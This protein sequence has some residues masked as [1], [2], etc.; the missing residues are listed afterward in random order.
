VGCPERDEVIAAQLDSVGSPLRIVER[1]DPEPGE[2]EVRVRVQACGVCGSDLFLQRGGFVGSPL[3]IIPGHEAAGVVE[4]LGPGVSGLSVG[5]QVAIYYIDAPAGTRYALAGRPNVGPGVRR[6]GVDVDGA[7]AEL[8]VRPAATLITP[9]RPLDPPVLAVL[10]DAVATPYHALVRIARLQPGECLLV[11]GVGGVGSNAVQLGRHF[12]ARVVAVS[13]SATKLALAKR[14]G[15]DEV[16]E[17]GPDLEGRIRKVTG[18]AGP[19][20]V[21]QCA[22]SAHLDAVAINVAGWLGRVVFV[23]T[24]TEAFE[25]KATS[26]VWREL[27]V[28]GSRGFV[29]DDIR[30][31]IDLYIAGAI[32]VDHLVEVLRPLKQANDALEDLRSG[33]VL[34]S[35]LVP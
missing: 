20:V 19:D 26:F 35:V 8:V 15:A 28:M 25:T 23:G 22:S 24:S 21:V 6:M 10:T 16:L 31:V 34:R 30:E 1:P 11:F 17:E 9:P 18:D 12:G 3:P 4:R 13:R 33:R 27:T 5:D 2:G 29:P 14:L 7:F 32:T